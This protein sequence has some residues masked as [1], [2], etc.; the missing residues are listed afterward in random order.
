MLD[1][2]FFLDVDCAVIMKTSIISGV[3]FY[4]CRILACPGV[5]TAR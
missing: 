2:F 5:G 3:E 1:N 4:W